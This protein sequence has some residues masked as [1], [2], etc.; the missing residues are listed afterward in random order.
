[1]HGQSKGG[2]VTFKVIGL[3]SDELLDMLL[4]A[5]DRQ[6]FASFDAQRIDIP[7][8]TSLTR[9]TL[10]VTKVEVDVRKKDIASRFVCQ[11]AQKNQAI[12][13]ISHK[14]LDKPEAGILFEMFITG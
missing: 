11:D 14:M 9:M 5:A 13:M 3:T 10:R 12:I 1:M 2:S 8:D 7:D 6:R 4:K